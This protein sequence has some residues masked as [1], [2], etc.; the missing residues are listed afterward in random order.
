MRSSLTIFTLSSL[1]TAVILSPIWIPLSLFSGFSFFGVGLMLS[2]CMI[3]GFFGVSATRRM[4]NKPL[5]VLI[6]FYNRD[7][8]TQRLLSYFE[9]K[10]FSYE[11]IKR[12]VYLF[13][14]E[15][16]RVSI[17]LRSMYQSIEISKI[18]IT[19]EIQEERA[20]VSGTEFV[21]VFM[22]NIQK[23]CSDI[24]SGDNAPYFPYWRF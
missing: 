17:F 13:T 11:E 21:S 19:I 10:G 14:P 2:I 12:D 20:I 8:F 16:R 5:A 23:E 7:L 22:R 15:T 24:N 4:I 3:T 1:L 18:Q 6:Q 9:Q